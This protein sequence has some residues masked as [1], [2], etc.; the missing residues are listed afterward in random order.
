[1]KTLF[2]FLLLLY[3]CCCTLVVE[4]P[5]DKE[6]EDSK[7]TLSLEKEIQ[8][9]SSILFCIRFQ[10]KD[11]LNKAFIFSGEDK[12]I[13]LRLEA[14][15]TIGSEYFGV[16]YVTINGSEL[17]F[18]IPSKI[19][20][21]EGYHFC[22]DSNGE[23]YKIIGNGVIWY[24]GNHTNKVLANM[25]T[26]SILLGSN[27]KKFASYEP[28]EGEISELNIWSKDLSIKE[29]KSIT[30][31]NNKTLTFLLEA[32]CSSLFIES[33]PLHVNLYLTLHFIGY[34]RKR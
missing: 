8:I 32:C 21:Y 22:F 5:L 11:N 20:P 7:T 19:L 6:Q 3:C 23:T 10:F 27:F 26:K 25:K 16:G 31:G 30:R 34:F 1:M 15:P 14:I 33:K 24:E 4:V 18:T 9:T 17:I 29:M 12:S 13:G 2:P 28:I